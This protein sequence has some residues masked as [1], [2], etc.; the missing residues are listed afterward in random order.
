[1]RLSPILAATFLLAVSSTAQV[2]AATDCSATPDMSGC[3]CSTLGSTVMSNDRKMIIACTLN[4]A[5]TASTI[6][7]SPITCANAGGCTWTSMTSGGGEGSTQT[8]Y[9]SPDGVHFAGCNSRLNKEYTNSTDKN[10]IVAITAV[11][12]GPNIGS[13]A[14]VDGKIVIRS[15]NSNS[16]EAT[17][18]PLT[19]VVPPGQS[20]KVESNGR[21]DGWVEWQ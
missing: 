2:Q 20:Y 7:N 10:R 16:G 11:Q 17:L 5:N 1:M 19:F 15:Y 21:C 13:R 3:T 4:T 18:I 6:N 12:T 8:V 14:L 9:A